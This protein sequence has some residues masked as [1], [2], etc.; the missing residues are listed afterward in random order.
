[1]TLDVTLLRLKPEDDNY[2]G[3][4]GDDHFKRTRAWG[5]AQFEGRAVGFVVILDI[6]ARLFSIKPEEKQ[7]LDLSDARAIGSALVNEMGLFVSRPIAQLM[8]PADGTER[9]EWVVTDADHVNGLLHRLK[10]RKRFTARA[11]APVPLRLREIT[12]QLIGAALT[13]LR[14]VNW[15]WN[16]T[17][18]LSPSNVPTLNLSTWEVNRDR[19]I[20]WTEDRELRELAARAFE[21]CETYAK[22]WSLAIQGV[23]NRATAPNHSVITVDRA[24]V[25]TSAPALFRLRETRDNLGSVVARLIVRIGTPDDKLALET[26]QR[27]K[28]AQ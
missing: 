23:P 20:D 28:A 26:A 15:C 17:G 6:R 10:E 25:L 16:D 11:S 24:A 7:E 2:K 5:K 4:G 19:F 21:L 22:L 9:A 8:I 12:E 18:N 27:A 14:E 13:N 1:M 3:Q